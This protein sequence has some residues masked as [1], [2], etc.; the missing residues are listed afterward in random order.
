MQRPWSRNKHSILRDGNTKRRPHL[1]SPVFSAVVWKGG[2][3][4][5]PITAEKANRVQQTI[6][7]RKYSWQIFAFRYIYFAAYALPNFS[8]L[9]TLFFK[10]QNQVFLIPLKSFTGNTHLLISCWNPSTLI[11]KNIPFVVS[12]P[13]DKIYSWRQVEY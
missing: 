11:F 12:Q 10:T 9:Y 7:A 3:S 2:F 13:V 6:P 5:G 8:K 1:Q 4:Y